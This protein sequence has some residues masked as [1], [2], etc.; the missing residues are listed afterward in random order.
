MLRGSHQGSIDGIIH[1]AS[2]VEGR[3]EIYSSV[4]ATKQPPRLNGWNGVW[5]ARMPSA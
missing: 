2:G 3:K 1:T 5:C 4:A